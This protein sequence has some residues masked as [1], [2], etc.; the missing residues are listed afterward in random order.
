MHAVEVETRQIALRLDVGQLSSLLPGVE[1]YEHVSLMDLLAGIK[2]D[3]LDTSGADGK[4]AGLPSIAPPE[5]HR[6]IN[7]R[8]LS[9]NRRTPTNRG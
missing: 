7:S 1:F 6:W 4:S 3:S 8:S 2:I 9:F 5:T